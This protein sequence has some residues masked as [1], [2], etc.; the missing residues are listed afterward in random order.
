MA[1]HGGPRCG[2]LPLV[3]DL[4]QRACHRT[5]DTSSALS[6]ARALLS[7]PQLLDNFPTFSHQLRHK[8]RSRA[9]TP[10]LLLSFPPLLNTLPTFS[11]QL[12]H[13]SRSRASTPRLLLS[14][15]PLLNTLPTCLHQARHEIR[16]RVNTPR[17]LLFSARSHTPLLTLSFAPRR[18]LSF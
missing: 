6:S 4:T 13:K 7:S 14:F 3:S 2:G 17:R 8:S 1:D 15:P 16:P 12:R 9:S 10:R 11:H 18:S 5:E